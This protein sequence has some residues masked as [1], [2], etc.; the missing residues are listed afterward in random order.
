MDN[1]ETPTI[2][3]TAQPGP[4]SMFLST[5]A[6]IALYGG[7]AG[8]GK[9]YALLLDALRHYDNPNFSGLIFRRERPMITT[10]GGLWSE[11]SNLFPLFGATPNQARLEF[12][13]PAPPES[14]SKLGALIKFDHLFLESDVLN[15]QGAQVAYIGFDEVTHFTKTQFFYMLSRLRSSSGVPGHVRMTCNPD[16]DS[17]VA[18]FFSWWIDQDTGFPIAER[19]GV[20]RW[21][22]R[23]GDE[24]IW[25]DERQ[26]LIDKYGKVE[27]PKSVTFISAKISD[28]KILLDKDPEYMS[29][30]MA[31]DLVTRAQLLDGNWKIRRSAG[32]VF[33]RSW[34]QEVEALPPNIVSRIRYWDR[35][36]TEPSP[37]NPN[38]DWTAGLKM[39]KDGQGRYYI[40]HVERFQG[41]PLKVKTTIRSMAEQDGRNCMIGIEVDPGQAGVA[42]SDDH[43]SNLAGFVVKKFPARVDKMTRALPLSAQAEAGNVFI[44][45][46][47]WN[48]KF[49]AEMESFDGEG[50]VKDDQVD[51]ASGAFNAI[52]GSKTTLSAMTKA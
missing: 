41:R 1:Q 33:R 34:F 42:E 4:Q 38:P 3:I 29:N 6:D 48:E 11:S 20:L 36:A 49:L 46:G 39:F 30:L 44:L 26:D 7:A 47:A 9:S 22:I 37:S 31:L 16:P 5:T 19:S 51:A 23:R 14:I 50:K 8:G 25:A 32:N 28:N 43:V 18:E 27:L 52:V 24:I 17:W 45:K 10:P 13:F 35:A 21:F 15:Y 40:V 2:N 12:R